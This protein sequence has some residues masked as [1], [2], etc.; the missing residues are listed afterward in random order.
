MMRT[1]LALCLTL[2]SASPALAASGIKRYIIGFK[3]GSDMSAR[4]EAVKALGVSQVDALPE[5]DAVVA[6]VPE[7][8]FNIQSFEAQALAQ[9]PVALVEEDFVTN[10]L[11]TEPVSFQNTPLPS[12]ASIK[13]TLI[14]FRRAAW[15][16]PALPPGVDA[17]ELPWGIQR[18]NAP[19]A[20]AK[21]QGA[22]VR[23]AVVDTGIDSSHPD[24]K[25]NYAGCY[26]AMDSK[27]SCMDD[28]SHGTHVS[29]TIAGALDGKGVA[30]V[31]PKAR[32][33]AVKVLDADGSGGLVG[34]IKG[35]LWCAKN[36]MQVANMSLGAPM[37]TVFMRL[38]VKYAASKGVA[39]I[40]AAGNSGGSVGYPA[41]YPD[42]IAVSASDVNDK[43]ADFSSRGPRVEFI[44]PGV[45][46]KSSVPG[47]GYDSYNGTSMATPHVA[48]L[49]ALAVSRGARGLDGVR[50]AL[51]RSAKSIGLKPTEEG[52]G[53][54]DAAAL[55]R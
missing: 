21:T 15:T 13:E 41:G 17:G 25:A 4:G 20:W 33:Y 54:I 52:S 45:N 29:G 44:A 5:L 28:N 12:W 31:A 39:I 10:W 27:K 8:R 23:V 55:A 32:L 50:A 43:I 6:E 16:P 37:G 2:L 51:K 19:A 24:L 30:G 49:A 35:I 34:I 38:A 14:P 46:V 18:V 7:E 9:R 36:D 40:A 11:V 47:G 1:I 26:N 53:M 42:T 48:G 3:P 22:G